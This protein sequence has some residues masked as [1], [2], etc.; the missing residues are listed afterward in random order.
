MTEHDAARW[1]AHP[2]ADAVHEFDVDTHRGLPT[3]PMRY[4]IGGQAEPQDSLQS[5]RLGEFDECRSDSPVGRGVES[6]FVVAA[7]KVPVTTT[8]R[9]PCRGTGPAVRM[10]PWCRSPP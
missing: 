3:A 4:R 2:A 8:A 1:H 10:P 5:D 6:E 7:S 9:R